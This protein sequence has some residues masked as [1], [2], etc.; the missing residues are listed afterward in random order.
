MTPLRDDEDE[1]GEFSEREAP[2]EPQAP[3]TRRRALLVGARLATGLVGVGIAAALVAAV[4]LA[5]LPSLRVTPLSELITPVPSAQQLVCPGA[6][7]RLADDTGQG[8]TTASA[9]GAARVRY[10]SSAGEADPVA[11]ADSDASTGGTDE[12]P[13]L[14]SAPIVDAAA[15]AELMISGA[16]SQQVTD[17]EFVGLAAV[18]CSRAS[19][20]SWLV[21]GSTAVGRTTLLTLS[22]PSE[23]AATVT[24]ELFGENGPISAPGTSGIIV[25]PSGQR[26]LSLAGF[27]P[28]LD[29]PVVHVTSTGGQVVASLQQ[30]TVRGLE[31]GGLDTVA[32]ATAP[33][34]D[35]VIPGLVITDVVAVQQLLA[36]GTGFADV[37]PALRL[38]APGETDAI[39]T[40]R[41]MPADSDAQ[42]AS[43]T[44]ALPAGVVTEIPL[45]GLVEGAYT[46]A[47]HTDQPAV[48]AARVTSAAAG[49]TDFAWLSAAPELSAR[50]QVSVAPGPAPTLHLH[51]PADTTA[52]VTV[53]AVG[54]GERTVTLKAGASVALAV[55][56]GE[57]YL[58][59]GFDRLVAAVSLAG[60]GMLARYAVQP[61]GAG[62]API[63]VYP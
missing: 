28:D 32:A 60:E 22:N 11:F 49:A 41:V 14:I 56:A 4:S 7:L 55:E 23:V 5:P 63:R 6:S 61:P 51:N 2:P 21:G 9:L 42:P 62:V 50:A 3:M 39:A 47:V 10:H 13:T 44:V 38:L 46:V 53:T 15:S 12:A 43:L 36:G 17:A 40:V 45:E 24:L 30:S 34:T 19:G 16:Q 27:Q 37:I 54:G 29:S 58:I 35:M 26:V 8:A 52:V 33:S 25:P 31:A 1:N 59:D 20:D 57:S 48:S 18:E